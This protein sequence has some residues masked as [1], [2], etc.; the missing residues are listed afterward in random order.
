MIKNFDE[1]Y[2]AIKASDYELTAENLSTA[3]QTI[4]KVLVATATDE[5]LKP[6]LD[7]LC[8][9]Y[10]I[11]IPR[12]VLIEL[13][14]GHLDLAMETFTHGISDTCQREILIGRLLNKI[15]APWWP[16]YG[17]GKEVYANFI[18]ELPTFLEK[19]GGKLVT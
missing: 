19:V 8:D 18:K 7:V 9:Y 1:F 6:A 14:Q 11:S 5:Q 10:G 2:E 17:D 3:E 12:D 4:L 15:G 13:L 16:C